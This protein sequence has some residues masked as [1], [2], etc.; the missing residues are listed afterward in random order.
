M[1]TKSQAVTI[2]PNPDRLQAPGSLPP[3]MVTRQQG[4]QLG[5]KGFDLASEV[6][7]VLALALDD[8]RVRMGVMAQ[9]MQ[10][11]ALGAYLHQVLAIG[12]ALLEVIGW[13]R[14]VQGVGC[15]CRRQPTT[16]HHGVGFGVLQV[17]L[18]KATG[19]VDHPHLKPLVVQA[20]ASASQ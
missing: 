5:F 20:S 15:M 9:G 19:R 3:G 16:A 8:C 6:R 13:R 18:S 12:Q 14:G 7:Q 10:V 17:Q 1:A 2:G 4:F 11:V